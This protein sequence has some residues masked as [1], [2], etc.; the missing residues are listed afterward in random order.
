MPEAMSQN[1]CVIIPAI[2]KNA[3]IPDQLVKKL[4]G[5]TLIQRALN[6]AKALVKE[7]DIY[8]VTDSEEISLICVRNGVNYHYDKT[9]RFHS[10]NLLCELKSYIEKQATEYEHLLIFR[11]DVPLV[12]QEDIQKGYDHFVRTDADIMVA[13]KKQEQRLWKELNGLPDQLICDEGTDSVLIEVKSFLI[14][15][16]CALNGECLQPKVIPYFLNEKAIEISSYQDWWICERLI[17]QKHIVFVVTG[18]PAI[19]LGHVFRA[20]SLAHEITDH[21]IT[22]LCTR[23]SELAVKQIAERD[24]KTI[25]QK[26]TLLEEVLN[27]EMDLVVNDILNTDAVYIKRLKQKGVKVV[28]FED[29]GPGAWAADL[30]INAVYP[31]DETLPE[32]FLCGSNYFCLRDEF[33]EVKKGRF[34][35][36]PQNL[37]I[38]FGGTD[39]KNFTFKTLSAVQRICEDNEIKILIVTGPGYQHHEKLL[40]YLSRMVYQNHEYVH[41]TGVISSIMEKADFAISSAGRTVYELAHMRVPAIIIAQNDREK[42]HFFARPEY[43][44]EYIGYMDLFDSGKM[45]SAFKR[46]LDS[47][48]RKTLHLRMKQF[49]FERNKKQVIRS[50]LS[51]LEEE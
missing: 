36:N 8:V 12:D 20:L 31:T 49:H 3:V 2:K 50:I 29:M 46:L 5:I 13:L 22:F 40:D 37:L 32:Q 10:K 15:R 44:F 33:L 6:T 24:Y 45:L 16:V 51:L 7:K 27:L 26:G 21:R 41:K 1:H 17:K 34:H 4:A 47:E 18:Y 14:I 48:Y 38:M 39:P 28:N 43:G 19:G 25:L 35:E 23:E 30:V 9:L 11:A 42:T